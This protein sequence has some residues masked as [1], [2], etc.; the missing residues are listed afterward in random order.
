M[1]IEIENAETI[2]ELVF[3]RVFM[4]GLDI[5]QHSQSVEGEH[6]RYDL[7][8]TYRLYALDAK[9]KRHYA[10]KINSI[11]VEDFLNLAEVKAQ[12]G[13]PS[14]LQ[15]IGAIQI[16]MAKLLEEKGRTSKATIV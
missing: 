7:H 5:K 3:N 4:E 12:A 11:E 2:P 16:A 13:D 8:V 1:G 15:A 9:N 6:P 10:T 14:L